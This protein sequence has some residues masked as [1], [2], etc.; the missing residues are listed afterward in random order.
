M[1]LGQFSD[2]LDNMNSYDAGRARRDNI[3]TR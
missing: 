3:H 1:D 2:E